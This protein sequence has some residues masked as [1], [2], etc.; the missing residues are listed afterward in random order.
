MPDVPP[1][2]LFDVMDTLVVDPFHHAIPSYFGLT[3]AGFLEQKHPTAWVEFERGELSPDEYA[4]KMFVDARQVVWRDFESHV[5]AAYRWVDGMA[6]L[7]RELRERKIEMHALS[8]Y[9]V[10]YRVLDVE[11]EIGR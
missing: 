3:L 2:I 4:A 9:P 6:E 5:R 1:V 7:L 8:N 11:L 10:L